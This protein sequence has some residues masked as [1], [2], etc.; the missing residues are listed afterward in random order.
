MMRCFGLAFG[1]SRS[2]R[3]TITRTRLC[4]F[5]ELRAITDYF[6]VSSDN[7][8]LTAVIVPSTLLTSVWT[9]LLFVSC[10]IAQLLV[11]IDYLRRFTSFWFKNVEKR[12]LT[13]IAKVA[14]TLIFVGA[15]AIKAVRRVY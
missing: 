5:L 10:L 14:A 7:V 15:M 8:T 9:F 2:R 12:P 4:E 11:P 3:A 1:S 13:A 6:T